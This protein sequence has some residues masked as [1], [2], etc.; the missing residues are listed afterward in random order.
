MN[1]EPPNTRTSEYLLAEIRS[2]G[3]IEWTLERF[4]DLVALDDDATLILRSCS[5]PE[6]AWVAAQRELIVCYELL[7]LYYLLSADQHRKAIESLL[8]PS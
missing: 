3:L 2:R 7:D 6:A 8:E 5:I 1:Y 4:N